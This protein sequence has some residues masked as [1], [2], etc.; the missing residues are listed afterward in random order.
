MINNTSIDTGKPLLGGVTATKKTI[1]GKTYI[2]IFATA[3]DYSR[4]GQSTAG[5]AAV[6]VAF[7]NQSDTDTWTSNLSLMPRN[8]DNTVYWGRLDAS[9]L[10]GGTYVLNYA[11]VVDASGNMA[12]YKMNGD[13][14]VSNSSDTKYFP[15]DLKKVTF[16]I[17]SDSGEPTTTAP[18]AAPSAQINDAYK[19][20]QMSELNFIPR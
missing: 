1:N 15:K 19:S 10:N 4:S 12:T 20:P 9:K 11:S 16:T 6:T 18:E 13:T 8:D 3:T 17:G 2:D 14:L 7:Q 5:V